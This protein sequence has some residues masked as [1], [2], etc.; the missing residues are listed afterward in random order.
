MRKLQTEKKLYLF[1]PRCG[2]DLRGQEGDPVR[3]P[4]CGRESDL[5]DLRI[6][7]TQINKQISRLS[8]ILSICALSLFFSAVFTP[9][10]PIWFRLSLEAKMAIVIPLSIWVWLAYRFYTMTGGKEGWLTVFIL[11]QVAVLLGITGM[12][13]F[14]WLNVHFY[15]P[16]HT[17]AE[18]VVMGLISFIPAGVCLAFMFILFAVMKMKQRLH[19]LLRDL[20]II[21]ALN[22]GNR[23]G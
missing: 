11:D 1:C 4:E 21:R 13:L 5:V 12:S 7:A 16:Q 3:C 8:S 14:Y 15:D 23:I 9:L 19:T 2:Y 6:S 17:G 22:A 10:F 20:A 18:R